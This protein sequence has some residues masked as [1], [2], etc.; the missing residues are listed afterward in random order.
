[1]AKA[2]DSRVS[3][4]IMSKDAKVW[5]KL[6]TKT[7]PTI[8]TADDAA[9]AYIRRRIKNVDDYF[10]AVVGRDYFEEFKHPYM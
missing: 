10:F 6:G 4:V 8:D 7:W 2:K 9:S 1:M 5:K 3:I